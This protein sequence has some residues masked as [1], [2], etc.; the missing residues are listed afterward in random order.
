M[1]DL[2]PGESCTLAF[3]VDIPPAKSV[4]TN[5][6]N[7]T[8]T[9]INMPWIT[10]YGLAKIIVNN[11]PNT[12]AID[13][14]AK[15][16][17]GKPIT[18]TFVA[19]DPDGDDVSYYVDW[20]DGTNSNWTSPSASGVDV[21]ATHTWSKKGTYVIK[22]KAKDV[23]DAESDWGTLSVSMPRLKISNNALLL[24]ILERFPHA[25]PIMRYLIGL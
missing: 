25:F 19:T 16:K 1:I 2:S 11:K 4:T 7:V 13:G 20:G 24:R 21:T 5:I 18:Y 10:G 6:M 17:V 9:A 14:P 12:P 8:A 3:Q 15:G 23:Y 22:A